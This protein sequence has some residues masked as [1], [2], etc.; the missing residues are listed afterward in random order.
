M[1]GELVK[2]LIIVDLWKQQIEMGSVYFRD[3]LLLED[4]HFRVLRRKTVRYFHLV[5]IMYRERLCSVAN[6]KESSL[7]TYELFQ[8]E[9]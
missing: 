7:Q 4:G 1:Y 3:C 2:L 6:E 5:T 8:Q 9:L